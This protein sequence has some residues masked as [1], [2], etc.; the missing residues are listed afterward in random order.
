MIVKFD[1]ILM[2]V[3]CPLWG[4]V[5]DCSPLSSLK[6]LQDFFIPNIAFKNVYISYLRLKIQVDELKLKLTRKADAT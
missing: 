4:H 6:R 3:E 2:I 1:F 5:S